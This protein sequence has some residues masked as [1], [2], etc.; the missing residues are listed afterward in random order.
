MEDRKMKNAG[1]N[2]RV[3]M[4]VF[5][6]FSLSVVLAPLAFAGKSDNS[7]VWAAKKEITAVD[8]Y[9]DTSR[10]VLVLSMHIHDGLVYYDPGKN[11][12]YPLL[13][14]KFTWVDNT[15]L[16]FDLR[17]GVVFHD[18][19][20]FGPEDVVYTINFIANEDNGVLNYGDIKWLDRAEEC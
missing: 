7:I 19:S 8:P 2:S 6:I 9:F 1:R 10:E 11:E 4:V 17:Q 14:T 20:S 13:A 3:L 16:E 15:T 12:Y 5:V 18:G